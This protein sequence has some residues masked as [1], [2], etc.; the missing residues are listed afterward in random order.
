MACDFIPTEERMESYYQELIDAM[1]DQ[2]G[3][4]IVPYVAPAVALE[5]GRYSESHRD[6]FELGKRVKKL[7]DREIR[8]KSYKI[9]T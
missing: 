7:I 9:S 8:S 1:G 4:I 5:D 2:K 3:L 6:Q